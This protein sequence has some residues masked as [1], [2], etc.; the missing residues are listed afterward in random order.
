MADLSLNP[1][2]PRHI[3]CVG[4]GGFGMSALAGLLREQGHTITGSD[5]QDSPLLR[6]LLQA[7]I[8]LE[9][10]KSN[11]PLPKNTELLIY[12]VAIPEEN[13]ERQA[14]KKLGLPEMTYFQALGQLS[15]NYQN[16][17][18]VAGTN[19]KSTT[20]AMIAWIFQQAGYHP[21]AIIGSPLIATGR[22]FMHG[23]EQ[24]FI[25]EACEYR[26]NFLS[27]QPTDVVITN[28]E[29]DHLDYFHDINDI[30]NAFESFTQN[31]QNNGRLFLNGDDPILKNTFNPQKKETWWYGLQNRQVDFHAKLLPSTPG[32]NRF[33]LKDVAESE[34]AE[35]QLTLPGDYNATNA[36]AAAS[37]ARAHKIPLSTIKKALESFRSTWRRFQRLPDFQGA[38]VIS[39]YAHHP[40]AIAVTIKA[41]RNFYPDKRIIAIFQPHQRNRTKK[42]FNDFVK[43]LGRADLILLPEIYEVAGREESQDQ[44]ISSQHLQAQLIKNKPTFFLT[45]LEETRKKIITTAS[46]NDVLLFMGAGDIYQLAESL[47]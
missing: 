14:G 12:S 32:I 30:T 2:N 29:A 5:Q 9:I 4:I 20:T 8:R 39:D 46:P 35:I 6:P 33:A 36:L 31:V 1:K 22:N 26:R 40:S 42:L 25:V 17:I 47:H 16:R 10:S 18:A 28:I 24:Y 23:R 38:I 44:N 19:G 34:T 43:T 41:A 27:L 15:K 11:S 13:W 3:H 45:D 21:T 37:V 7:G